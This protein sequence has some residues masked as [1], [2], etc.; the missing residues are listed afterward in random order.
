MEV[1]DIFAEINKVPRPSKREEKMCA[2]LI[3]FAEKHNL[4]HE[5]LP[6]EPG[7]KTG[8]IIIR[9]PATPGYE[10][11]PGVVLQGHIDIGSA[12]HCAGYMQNAVTGQQG[13]HQQQSSILPLA[14][15]PA[16]RKQQA[17]RSLPQEPHSPLDAFAVLNNSYP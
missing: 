6:V 17:S 7:A 3:A 11:H 15:A 10:N 14:A 13:Q 5:F 12:F 8:N 4:E 2:W 16:H 1:F 9:K